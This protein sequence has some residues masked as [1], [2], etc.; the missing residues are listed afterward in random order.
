MKLE[1]SAVSNSKHEWWEQLIEQWQTQRAV[2]ILIS[3]NE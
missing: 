2:L 3:R 1:K